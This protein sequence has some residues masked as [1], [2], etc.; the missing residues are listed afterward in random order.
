LTR[1]WR[2]TGLIEAAV[3][4]ANGRRKIFAAVVP[5]GRPLL[6]ACL[7]RGVEPVTSS[8]AQDVVIDEPA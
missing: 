6:K 1:H 7:D 8:R 5:L 2:G 4:G 3:Q